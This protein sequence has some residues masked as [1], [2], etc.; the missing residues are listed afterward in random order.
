MALFT[1][2]AESKDVG[3][4]VL[5]ATIS[6]SSMAFVASTSLTVALPAI[7]RELGARG[8]DLIW[9]PN[10]Y[11]LVQASLIIVCGSLGDHFGRNRICVTGILLF[12]L[13][14]LVCGVSTSTGI[15][16][17]G[18]FAQGFGSA[19]IIPNSLA[20]VSAYFSQRRH[21]WAIGIWTGFTVFSTGLA[22]VLG[23]V[24]TDLGAWRLVFFIHIPFGFAAA[25]FLIRNVPESNNKE[26]PKRMSL[27]GALL[28]SCGLGGITFGFIESSTY[29]FESPLIMV[30]IAG[31]IMLLVK[32]LNDERENKHAI[33]PLM[34]FKSRTF[35]AANFITIMLNG[36][37]GPA[38]LYLPLNLIQIQG[39]SATS[40]GISLLPMTIL[41]I[42]TSAMVGVIVDRRGPRFPLAIGLA[43]TAIGFV[44]FATVGTT[45]GPDEYFTTFFLPISLF[46]LG[47]GLSFAPLTIA[48]LAS[49]P[50]DN[51]GIAS[52]VNS[53][54]SRAGQVLII[55]IFGGLAISWFAQLLLNDPAIKSL[56]AEAQ[57]ML[58]ADAGDMAETAIPDTL[59]DAEQESVR[60]VLREAF[61]ATFSILMWIGAAL[62][63]VSALIAYFFIEDY[64]FIREEDVEDM[65][66]PVPA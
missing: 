59:S 29:G 66:V 38:I 48:A 46:G 61:A 10:S 9:I 18:R 20:I 16:I 14:S 65:P 32:F 31:G 33:L 28:V 6:A 19:M 30:A 45:N 3:F 47:L 56:P 44:S 57:S 4:W 42:L 7:Q 1:S 27:V 36:V 24:L 2:K 26:A 22:P 21:A 62:C 50:A 43:I 63:L 37:L 39:Y 53:T 23:G 40:A 25:Y 15:L 64:I 11:V 55:G 12:A 52:G 5:F 49:A 54:M 34:L 35:S 8:A 17:A 41:L 58:A 13:A 51:A 60:Q